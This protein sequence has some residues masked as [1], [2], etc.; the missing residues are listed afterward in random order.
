[1]YTEQAEAGQPI[2]PRPLGAVERLSLTLNEAVESPEGTEP[3]PLRTGLRALQAR[4]VRGGAGEILDV[5]I[6]GTELRL[7]AHA[8]ARLHTS[9]ARPA[10][11]L[12]TGAKEAKRAR[13]RA[14]LR[15]PRAP[16]RGAA[17]QP[18]AA[19]L[20]TRVEARE[21]RAYRRT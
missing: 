17:T 15:R 7:A 18:R 2:L 14:A 19:P 1:L 6:P 3:E 21:R 9:A 4:V 13:A 5:V 10:G 8:L 16:P 20:A 11:A 12:R